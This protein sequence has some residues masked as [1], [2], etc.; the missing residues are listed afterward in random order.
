MTGLNPEPPKSAIAF[1]FAGIQGLVFPSTVGGDDNLVV[2]RMNRR[3]KAL[4][5]QN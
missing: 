3:R 4:S 5:L 1:R 2:Y